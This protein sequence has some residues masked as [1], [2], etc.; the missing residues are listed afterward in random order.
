MEK[1]INKKYDPSL[2]ESKWYKFWLDSNF[3]KS[4]VDSSKDPYTLLMP[5]PNVTGV[6]HMGHVL[7]NTIQDILVRRARLLG[8][9]A[10][11]VPGIDHAS[12]A[13][14]A[15]V[16]QKL[17]KEGIQKKDL[18]REEFLKHA[19]EWKDKH[20][21]IIFN[22]LKRLG[23]SCDWDRVK[24]TMDDDM[25]ESVISI[26]IDLYEKGLIYKGERM[27]NWDSQAKTAVS[28]EE[29]IYKE[30][31]SALYYIDYKLVDSDEIIT[32][33]TTRP[34][35]ILGDT[36]ICVHPDDKR[37][38][39]LIGKRVL[40]PLLNRDIPI[41]TD[42][43]IDP[44]FGTGA[45]KV[46]PAHDINDYD[47]GKKNNLEIIS[48]IDDD[49]LIH[50]DG[51]LYV[52]KDRFDVR[53]EIVNDIDSIGQL[54]K[55]EFIKNKIG[56]S[57]RTNE[58]IEPK[59]SMQWFFD[60]KGIS[61]PALESVLKDE[62]NFFPSNFKKT[63]KYWMENIKDWCISRQLWWGHRIPVFYYQKDK[64]VVAKNINQALEKAKFNSGDNTLK[65]SDLHQDEDVL[66][67]W[68]SSWIWPISVFDGIRNPKNEEINYYYPTN[69]LVTGPDI[70]FFWVAR[71]VMAGFSFRDKF[72]FKNVYFT[73]IV[74][75]KKRRKMSKSLGNSPDAIELINK[76][77]ADGVRSGMLF[78]SNA[79]ND[80]LFDESLCE[81]GRNFSNK[82]WNAFRLVDS[83]KVSEKVDL[84]INKYAIDW[85]EN[86]LLFELSLVNQSFDKFR[87]SEALMRIYKLI[88]DDFCSSYLEIIKP[89]N[90]VIDSITKDK[91]IYFFEK[92]MICLHPFM[93]FITEQIWHDLKVRSKLDTI[94]FDKWPEALDFDKNIL[95]EFNYL[96]QVITAIR[97]VRKEQ[98]VSVHKKLDIYTK[99]KFNFSQQLILKKIC[100]L[101]SIKYISNPL[102]GMFPFLVKTEKYYLNIDFDSKEEANKINKEII[103]YKNFLNSIEKKL[104]NK[105]FVNNAPDKVIM[106]EKKKKEDTILK[107]KYLENQV[108]SF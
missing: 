55:T 72:P 9:N 76:Y 8:Y 56:F 7:N 69:D 26:F 27:V 48:V 50:E 103:R 33:A 43:Y 22:Q 73:G 44:E 74:R 10:C 57:E 61:K 29:V 80:L 54:N 58:V 21:D 79:G 63:Y 98:S 14:E 35:T 88:W 40:V 28:D 64:F 46:T 4:N 102:E 107:I 39:S 67:T 87:V 15:K 83:W 37:Y 60:V 85:F 51:K 94:I 68:F 91:T 106:L 25:S 53:E 78:S 66:D 71:M 45:L 62:I 84:K 18:S 32:V 92:L 20:G 90:K 1:K 42:A 17:K 101:E 41:I 11:W 100:G 104:N 5:P 6:L 36:G 95:M 13:T 2:I 52:G 93:P 108:L 16:V 19:W 70:L 89:S 86:K 96:F 75:D 105:K 77:G 12:I 97:K 59:L 82:I 34:E 23:A 65:T 31:D 47:I 3:F 38:K 81:Q 24:F 30:Q 99:K 49:G